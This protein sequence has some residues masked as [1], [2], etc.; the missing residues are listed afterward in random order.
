MGLFPA[1]SLL[2]VLYC[3]VLASALGRLDIDEAQTYT[4]DTS[5]EC[6]WVVTFMALA[7]IGI[8]QVDTFHV[9]G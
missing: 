4:D 2:P 8:S 1:S 5:L 9:G 7:V 6:E 3:T